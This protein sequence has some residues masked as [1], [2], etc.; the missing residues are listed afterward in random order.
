LKFLVLANA[1]TSASNRCYVRNRKFGFQVP[2]IAA[3]SRSIGV[4]DAFVCH[5]FI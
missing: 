3:E 2:K 5:F 4:V 1:A